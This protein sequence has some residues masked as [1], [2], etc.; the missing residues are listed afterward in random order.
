MDPTL[1]R[2]S[3]ADALRAVL[4]HPI[5]TMAV[6]R[7]P[8]DPSCAG[9]VI[10]GEV[11][12]REDVPPFTRSSVDGFAVRAQE[13]RSARANAAIRLTIAGDI[14]MGA[15]PD[16]ELPA[17]HA[18]R[19]P[20]GGWLPDG[21]TGVV[22]KEDCNDLGAVVEVVDGA[23]SEDHITRQGADIR[24]GEVL[25]SRGSVVTPASVGMLSGAGVAELP[26]FAQPRVGLLVTGDEI[27]SPGAPLHA[28]AVR[29]INSLSLS[30][31]LRAMGFAPV[32]YERVVDRKDVFAAAF[33][34]ALG[35]CDAVVISGGSS[36]G[37]RDYTPQIVAAAGAPGVIVH[38]VRARPGRPTM[39]ALVG[40]KPVIGLPGN[41]VS[42]LVMLETLG[43]PIL[44]RLY[45]KKDRTLPVRA[46]LASRL[47]LD[48]ELE[49]LV[50]VA[51]S[52][53]KGG[54]DATPLLGTSAQMHVLGFA[55]ALIS[56]PEGS[57]ALE[58]GQ[59][60][61]ATP[62]SRVTSLR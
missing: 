10:A 12:A 44:L 36:V 29:D 40:D 6:E 28:G 23:G 13:V 21:A 25:A 27:V 20:T 15:R 42:A 38:G 47:A 39:L 33:A 3:L 1:R 54:V 35:E 45:D 30:A 50:P 18:M 48:P 24:R 57:G 43:K 7:V 51:L 37:E 59:L 52:R 5:H 19:V 58:E 22:K 14:A 31:T 17:L 55:D 16:T 9:R 46:R 62:L 60:V 61:D 34:R 41:P 4:A 8:I 2:V 32:A 26:L 53:S 49:H 11:T 56:V